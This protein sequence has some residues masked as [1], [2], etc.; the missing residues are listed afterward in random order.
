MRRYI[1]LLG[2]FLRT[3]I[4]LQMEYRA[5]FVIYLVS[6]LLQ[7]C[8]ALFG[9]FILSGDG[10]PIGGWSYREASVVVGIFT[11]MQGFIGAVL[12]PNLNKMSEMVRNGTMDFTLLK[13]IDAQFLV[14]TRNV[15]PF[16]MI[17]CIIGLIIIVVASSGLPEMR[18]LTIVLGCVLLGAAML[19]VYA[20]WFMLTTTAF[21]FVKVANIT[22]L[23]EG[24]FHAGQFPIS[25][26]PSWVRVL[27]TFI[28][29]IA[30]ITTAPAEALIGRF[31]I[32]TIVAALVLALLLLVA[33]RWLWNFA[34]SSYTSAS[35]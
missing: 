7:A 21:W 24:F 26:F 1:R 19:I 12:I 30:F 27:F 28:L 11:I 9:L 14:S 4:S 22:Q 5:N 2:V 10:E 17:D 8:G 23:F 16:G 25:A 3:T 18:P 20:I 33:A 6:A 13:P 32:N 31:S 29:P 35:S 15:E 34:V